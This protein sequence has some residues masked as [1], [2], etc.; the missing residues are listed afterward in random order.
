MTVMGAEAC[1][2]GTFGSGTP[3]PDVRRLSGIG[4]RG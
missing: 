2:G 4:V 3:D 1:P